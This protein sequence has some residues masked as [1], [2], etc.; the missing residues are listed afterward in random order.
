MQ[1]IAIDF[2]TANEE[3]GS[4]CAIGLAWIEDGRVTRR[5]ERLIRPKDMRFSGFNIAIHGIRPQ[6]VKN[7]PEFPEVL[8]EFA[9]DFEDSLVLAH[10]A[11]FDISVMRATL[12]KY[13]LPY[14]EFTYLCTV[15]IAQHTWPHL[16]SAAL[17][18]V[19]SHIGIEFD[20]HQAGAD[21]YACAEVA[22]AAA[23]Q[24]EAASI[25]AI[26]EKIKVRA[27]YLRCNG[28]TP[29]SAPRPQGRTRRSWV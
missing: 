11:A 25:A 27:G 12:D 14:P 22:L 13:R 8:A 28:Y 20:H 1:T 5:E 7:K 9:D 18:K 26:P 23:R 24:M 3:R 4:A 15:K 2:E 16:P 6:D 17:N 29:C 21:A 10:N 19:A